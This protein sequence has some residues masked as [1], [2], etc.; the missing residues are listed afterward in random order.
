[1]GRSS[2][3]SDRKLEDARE[4][5]NRAVKLP[6]SYPST[7]PNAWNNLGLIATRQNQI[8]E[9]IPYLQEALKL[10]PDYPVALNNLGNAFRQQ[11]RWEEARKVPI[12]S[13]K[14][15]VNLSTGRSN[16]P[17]ATHPLY[18]T[19][20]ITLGLLQLARTRSLRRFRT[21]RKP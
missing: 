13:W 20:G 14:M 10:S 17:R 21:F 12:A 2:Q 8:A 4:S 7:L 19:P 5:F 3:S 18:P 9:A 6:S 11:K 1:M 15:L 16:C